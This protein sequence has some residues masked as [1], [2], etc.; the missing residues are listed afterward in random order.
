MK[1]F[2][3]SM[4]IFSCALA[5]FAAVATHPVKEN[6]YDEAARFIAGKPISVDS[7]LAA[8]CKGEF[9]TAY[10]KEIRSTWDGFQQKNLQ[11]IS[12]WWAPYAPPQKARTVF[13][14]FS[15]PDILN[16]LAFYPDAD[17]YIMF[18]LENPGVFPD[19]RR[20]DQRH[21]HAG[22]IGLKNSLGNILHLNFFRTESMEK[23]LGNDSFNSIT[24]VIMFFLSISDYEIVNVRAI[25]I[26]E[27]SEIVPARTGNGIPGTEITF[28]RKGG[29]LKKVRYFMLNVM[30]GALAKTPPDFLFF[31]KTQAPFDT[32]IKSASYLMHDDPGDF[33][34]IRNAILAGSSCIVEDDSGIP[35]K[36]F[37]AGKWRVQYHGYYD[38]PTK[39]FANRFQPDLKAAM[40]AGSTG[41][42]PFGY[43]YDYRPGKANLISAR[44]LQ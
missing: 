13:Y 14:P 19:P 27:V 41:P 15:G 12:A 8:Y 29:E 43:G 35:V 18:G 5:V 33:T 23:H 11:K 2:I 26:N 32:I 39:L 21:F 36:Y 6:L 30:N 37:T 28:R 42:L 3:I 1:K 34:S 44:R 10:A 7:P 20:M 24:G 4:T 22:F 31:L 17:L 40:R 38:A 16:A 9:Y 25:A